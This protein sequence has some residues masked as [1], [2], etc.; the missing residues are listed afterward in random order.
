M[1]K[2]SLNRY[3]GSLYFASYRIN[4]VDLCCPACGNELEA[5]EYRTSPIRDSFID[6]YLEGDRL[7]VANDPQKIIT[8]LCPRCMTRVTIPFDTIKKRDGRE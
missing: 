1:G 4:L 5:S 2:V 3:V 8:F 6:P 7:P